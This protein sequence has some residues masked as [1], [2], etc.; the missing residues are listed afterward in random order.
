MVRHWKIVEDR[1]KSPFGF[2]AEVIQEK[3]TEFACCSC[4]FKSE[5]V[6]VK[7]VS[8]PFRHRA[9]CNALARVAEWHCWR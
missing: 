8:V 2:R 4:M 7:Q 3:T 5:P 1:K 9:K 6:I